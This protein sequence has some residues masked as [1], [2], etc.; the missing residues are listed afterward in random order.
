[1]SKL[2]WMPLLMISLSLLLA[3][4]TQPGPTG[5]PTPTPRPLPTLGTPVD[6]T[7]SQNVTIKIIDTNTNIT[8]FWYDHPNVKI[9]VGTTVTWVNIS[10]APHTITSGTAGAPDGKFDSTTQNPVLQPNNQGASSTFS[11]TF[12]KAGSYPYYCSLHPY[13]IG[14]V[15]VVAQQSGE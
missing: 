14:L 2:R 11:V 1:M 7:G 15:Q 6:L 5:N 13:M 3:G 10:S 4:C 9:K 8:G 12:T